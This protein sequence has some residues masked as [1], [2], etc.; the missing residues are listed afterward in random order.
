MHLSTR[1]TDIIQLFMSTS[2]WNLSLH[3]CTTSALL[4]EPSCQ[5]AEFNSEG[6]FKYAEVHHTEINVLKYILI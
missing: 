3:A 2:N 6:L 4:T 1:I 5:H